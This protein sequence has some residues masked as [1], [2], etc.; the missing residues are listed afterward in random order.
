MKR[1]IRG[2]VIKIEDEYTIILDLIADHG[3]EEGMIFI[4]YEEGEKIS[5]SKGKS[6]GK[7]EYQKVKVRIIN[8]SSNFSIAESDEWY[9]DIPYGDYGDYDFTEQFKRQKKIA[10]FSE[11]KQKEKNE[12]TKRKKSLSEKI[13]ERRIKRFVNVGDLVKSKRPVKFDYDPTNLL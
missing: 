3:V 6:L 11:K 1:F 12:I 13:K 2:K 4:V 10:D 7:I 9:Y 5:D 8:V